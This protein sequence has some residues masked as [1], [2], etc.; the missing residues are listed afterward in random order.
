MITRTPRTLAKDV[1]G[2]AAV[3]MALMSAFILLP[4]LGGF[5]GITQAM[6]LQS[7]LDR[8]VH[9][10]LMSAW[11]QPTLTGTT[12]STAMTTAVTDGFGSGTAPTTTATAAW[13]CISPTGTRAGATSVA[14][15]TTCTAPQVL[16]KWVTIASTVGFTPIINVDIGGWNQA[17]HGGVVTLAATAT[18]RVQ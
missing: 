3:E 16:G 11:G 12:L 2:I 7:R 14:S 6:E 5:V 10:A 18:V 9:A 8:G 4:M 15:A 17:G 13:Y 1:R